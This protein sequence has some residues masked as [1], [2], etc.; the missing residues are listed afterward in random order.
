MSIR[1]S[2]AAAAAVAVLALTACS[3]G[4]G[5]STT[6]PAGDGSR[7]DLLRVGVINDVSSWDPA[8]AAPSADL[9][10]MERAI[11]DTLLLTDLEGEVIAGLAEEWA[12]VNDERTELE[13]KIRE[14]VTF[15]DGTALDAEAVKINLDNFMAG[16]GPMAAQLGGV[17]AVEAADAQTVRLT[18]GAPNPALLFNLTRQAGL[19]ASPA[20]IE[21]GSIATDPVGTGPYVLDAASVRGSQYVMTAR[22]DYWQPDYQM[23]NSLNF[24][25]LADPTARANA[26]TSKQIDVTLVQPGQIEQV[27][28]QGAEI[29]TWTAS[30]MGLI[31]MDRNGAMAPELEDV[32]VRQAI[33]H[34]FDRD[35]ILEQAGKGLGEK[36]AQLFGTGTTAYVEELDEAYPYDPE[37]A[38]A[39]LAEAGYADGFTV[40]MAF[41]PPGEF[42]AP[43]ITQQL[44]DIGITVEKVSITPQQFSSSISG[45][46]Y[47][48]GWTV[49]G[50]DPAWVT[51]QRNI[52]PE[53]AYN[54]FGTTNDDVAA[55]ID[56][57][58]NA[59]DADDAGEELNRYLVDNA[60]FAPWYRVGASYAYN[61][62]VVSEIR[63][64]VDYSSVPLLFG[65]VPAK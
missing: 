62:D 35:L 15:S 32:R 12:Y 9:L 13:L 26:L 57:T 37:K 30:V 23:W 60:W 24:R 52:L 20:G 17:Q 10:E 25:V 53:S 45:G 29:A 65:Y 7:G 14:G 49:Q 2:L 8:Q 16:N 44:G 63:N 55:L 38:R 33:N 47:A 6:S 58:R 28:A 43:F 54:P 4:G 51:V 31:L 3:G 56:Q 34:A 18:L 39:L 48:M 22:E 21:S 59:G 27:E 40:P 41:A 1:K 36:T 50:L 46:E 61:P 19:I 11:Y 5:G 42:V 64:I